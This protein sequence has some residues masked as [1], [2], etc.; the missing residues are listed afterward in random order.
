M[1]CGFHLNYSTVQIALQHAAGFSV[2]AEGNVGGGAG[3]GATCHLGQVGRMLQADTRDASVATTITIGIDY[4]HNQNATR[5][6]PFKI[7][8]TRA[9]VGY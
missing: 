8:I 5:T 2:H 9:S 7:G 6:H 1:K 4:M 3:T